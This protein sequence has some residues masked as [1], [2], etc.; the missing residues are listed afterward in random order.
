MW[1]FD[2]V[3]PCGYMGWITCLCLTSSSCFLQWLQSP[4][5]G[6]MVSV[7]DRETAQRSVSWIRSGPPQTL[8]Y[9]HLHQTYKWH[10]PVGSPALQFET[11]ESFSCDTVC[12]ADT[13]AIYFQLW[14]NLCKKFQLISVFNGL[15]LSPIFL[16][17][18][19]CLCRWALHRLSEVTLDCQ[20]ETLGGGGVE[21]LSQLNPGGCSLIEQQAHRTAH[22]GWVFLCSWRKDRGLLLEVSGPS[23]KQVN[24]HD[25]QC[26][27][28]VWGRGEGAGL[29]SGLVGF[30]CE[31][32]LYNCR[33][34]CFLYEVMTHPLSCS[35]C[36]LVRC[37]ELSILW[38]WTAHEKYFSYRRL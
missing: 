29:G 26:T 24:S 19:C 36:S 15:P 6:S 4:P 28:E 30:Y 3:L 13:P 34:T 22:R 1:Q 33:V 38:C 5:A 16:F 7:L 32:N 12:S 9:P 25:S 27:E 20:T 23:R 10:P 8:C 31:M 35:V 11:L 14:M 18:C 17:M 37:L 2:R 21:R